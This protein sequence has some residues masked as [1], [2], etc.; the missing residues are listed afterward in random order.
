LSAVS[1]TE[2]YD[3]NQINSVY[4]TKSIVKSFHPLKASSQNILTQTKKH[5]RFK[6]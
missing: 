2:E 3:P 5:Y 4:I 1:I 6:N